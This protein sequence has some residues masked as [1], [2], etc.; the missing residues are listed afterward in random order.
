MYAL[1]VCSLQ[2]HL[3]KILVLTCRWLGISLWFLKKL[4][5][6]IMEFYLLCCLWFSFLLLISSTNECDWLKDHIRAQQPSFS[7]AIIN[8]WKEVYLEERDGNELE[9]GYRLMRRRKIGS[10]SGMSWWKAEWKENLSTMLVQWLI[11][12]RRWH[13]S[14]I[15]VK[16]TLSS[17]GLFLVSSSLKKDFGSK[18]LKDLKSQWN[19]KTTTDLKT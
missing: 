18:A 19:I 11:G 10:I 5:N 7:L 4:I 14:S 12:N 15:K 3:S 13:W 17:F 8:R 6:T 1:F 16:K 9:I 2:F